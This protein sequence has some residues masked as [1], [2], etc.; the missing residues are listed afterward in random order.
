MPIVSLAVFEPQSLTGSQ[1][2]HTI[3][4]FLWHSHYLLE[5]ILA[6]NFALVA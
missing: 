3:S 1:L 5:S 6:G 4:V 2:T